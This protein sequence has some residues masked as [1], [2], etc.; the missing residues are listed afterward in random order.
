MKILLCCLF[1]LCVNAA[2]KD[3]S[4]VF[5]SIY[6][7]LEWGVAED[8]DPSSGWG[9][10]P[11]NTSNYMQFLTNFIRSAGIRDVV[12][13]GCGSWEFSRYFRLERSELCWG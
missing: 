11:D 5:T 10:F 4:E 7:N 8:G 13:L 9:S 6:S 3:C 12:D 2:E 1:F